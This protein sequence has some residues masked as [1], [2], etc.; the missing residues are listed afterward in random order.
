MAVGLC[1]V[2]IMLLAKTKVRITSCE[3][4]SA[5]DYCTNQKGRRELEL[6]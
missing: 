1:P 2:K 6:V 3:A 5:I 4:G